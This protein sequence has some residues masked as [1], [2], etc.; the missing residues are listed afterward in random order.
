MA[1]S[2]TIFRQ[3]RVAARRAAAHATIE[4]SRPPDTP[5]R[6]ELKLDAQLSMQRVATPRSLWASAWNPLSVTFVHSHGD[7]QL[8]KRRKPRNAVRHSPGSSTFTP[9]RQVS[10]LGA[11]AL[12]RNRAI[13][14]LAT[15]DTERSEE[16]TSEL[17]SLMR[18]SYSVFS[19]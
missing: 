10:L 18:I 3:R 2:S 17:Q 14:S 15:P 6:V 16:H 5:I 11:P 8:S 4:E 13:A 1:S 19:L 12:A 7:H 9:S